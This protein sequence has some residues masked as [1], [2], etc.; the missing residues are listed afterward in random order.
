MVIITPMAI[1][2]DISKLS[3]LGVLAFLASL[4][5]VACFT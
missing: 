5:L 1:W 3:F 2:R 4:L